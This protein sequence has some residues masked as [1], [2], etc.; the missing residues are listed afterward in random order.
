MR[1]SSSD[2][3]SR[4][5]LSSGSIP[6]IR[7]F[8][9][10]VVLGILLAAIGVAH[11]A[12]HGDT[13]LLKSIPRHD[14]RI[15]DL[16]VFLRGNDLVLVLCS[17][18]TIP[19]EV[20]EYKFPSDLTF[21]FH[22]DNDSEVRFDDPDALATWGGTIVDP[23]RIREDIIFQITFDKHHKPRIKFEGISGRARNFVSLF[24]GL[25]D[26]PFI[27]G[28]RIG[29]NVAAIVLEFPL[30]LVIDS[31][32]TLL[33]WATSKVPE[34]HGPLADSAGR[35]LRNQFPENDPMNTMR[36]KI[37]FQALG[38]PP[39]VVIFD[40]TL[41]AAFP[42]GR[43]LVDDVVDLVGDP[44]P[45]NNDDPFPDENDIPFLDV[46]PYLAPPHKP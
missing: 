40:T 45:L 19:S 36:P 44:R 20:T 27:R 24:T 18:P 13:A 42:N 11:G 12:D 16:F 32:S 33:V 5:S 3:R 10:L 7:R 30:D 14:A 37:H 8:C 22:I 35:A 21:R 6:A 41:P 38:V 31:Q 25:R 15:T 4:E 34:I 9:A 2:L 39:D 43:E 17:D 1:I 29:R 26:D 46:F 23:N 28:P